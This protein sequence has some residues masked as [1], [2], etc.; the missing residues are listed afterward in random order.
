M[1]LPKRLQQDLQK[2][3]PRELKALRAWLDQLIHQAS[4]GLNTVPLRGTMN[5]KRSLRHYTYRR[6]YVKCGKKG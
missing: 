3:S 4:P 5:V 2:L 6:E 1:P